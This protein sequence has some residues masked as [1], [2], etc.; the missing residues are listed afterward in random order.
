ML[1]HDVNIRILFNNKDIDIANK[2][3]SINSIGLGNKIEI[4][5]F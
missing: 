5:I 1:K 3:I 4:W 2:F